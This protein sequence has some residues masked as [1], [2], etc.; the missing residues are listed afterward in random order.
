MKD[1]KALTKII[2][3]DKIAKIDLFKP[4]STSPN[5][6]HQLYQGIR[7]G[8]FLDDQTAA[9]HF[10][11][12]NEYQSQYYWTLKSRL[13]TQLLNTLIFLEPMPHETDIQKAH[14]QCYKTLAVVHQL[15]ARGIQDAAAKQAR[16][17]L[18]KALQYD[19]TLVVFDMANYLQYYYA[20]LIGDQTKFKKYAEIAK[21]YQAQLHAEQTAQQYMLEI[22]VHFAQ[23]KTIDPELLLLAKSYIEPLEALL[24]KFD[25]NRLHLYTYN[26]LIMTYEMEANHRKVIATCNRA[27]DF[28]TQKTNAVP[29]SANFIFQFKKIPAA[30][31]L[32]DFQTAQSNINAALQDLRPNIRNWHIVLQH[33]AIL[34]F[35]AQQ[36]SLTADALDAYQKH[37][38]RPNPNLREQWD[39]LE[40]YY[41]FMTQDTK[42]RL[43]RFLNNVPTYSKDKRGHNINI[44][45]VQILFLLQSERYD[46]VQDRIR[47]LLDYSKRHLRVNE[48]FRSNC[49][50]K[51]LTTLPAGG[52]H[53]KRI[54]PR[55]KKYLTKLKSLPLKNAKQPFELEIIPYEM[56]WAEIISRFP[57]L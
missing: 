14:Y 43:P 38:K 5:Q 29:A 17:A 15:R 6:L 48:D 35:H 32:Q 52:F 18:K 19:F 21:K 31:L 2:T 23:S 55:A 42:F 51:L 11:P 57:K 3:P 47:S 24:P 54:L 30:T 50:I 41:K 27:I 28:F 26:L 44:L 12:A 49:F 1:L 46:Q 36:L 25:S 33:Q 4:P 7:S 20:H 8:Q 16:K 13:E 34:G 10:F 39:I 56:L 40:A 22:S 53:L 45:I 9:N 37:K